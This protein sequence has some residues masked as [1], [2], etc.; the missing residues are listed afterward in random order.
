[1]RSSIWKTDLFS[2]SDFLFWGL[3]LKY[4][5]RRE[6]GRFVLTK[7]EVTGQ[8]LV[9]EVAITRLEASSG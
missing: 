3:G 1:M 7:Q 8:F 6:G 2:E 9:M 5:Y 4:E